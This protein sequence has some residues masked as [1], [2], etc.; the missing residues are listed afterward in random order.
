MK[1]E[2]ETLRV[3]GAEVVGVSTD[4]LESH[5]KFCQAVGG[6]PFPLASDEHLEAVK[7]YGVLGEDNKRSRRAIFVIDRG[8]VLLH[9]IGWYQPG[10]IG[11]FLEIFQSVGAV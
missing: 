8:G 4:N 7:L 2:Y 1:G 5:L 6:C 10:N 11:Q 9:Q 3:A